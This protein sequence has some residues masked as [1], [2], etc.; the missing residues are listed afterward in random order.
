MLDAI[1][2]T[3]THYA[4]RKRPFR[5]VVLRPWPVSLPR[6]P[7][8]YDAIKGLPGMWKK[9]RVIQARRVVG[10]W[11]IRGVMEKGWPL[12]SKE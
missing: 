11:E 4:G 10:A 3:V 8:E 2:L 12:R 5:L 7:A 9:R 6:H 1:D